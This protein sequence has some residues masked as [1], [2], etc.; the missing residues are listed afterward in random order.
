MIELSTG[1]VGID[2][3]C[4]GVRSLQATF[5]VALFL[6]AFYRMTPWRRVLLV[7]A[8]AC[9]AFVCNIGRTFLL[10]EVAANDGIAAISRWHDPAGFTIL[11]MAG[12]AETE[13][14]QAVAK[15]PVCLVMGSEGEGL[16]RLTRE[17]CDQ[18]VKI[19]IA[20]TMESLNMSVATGVALSILTRSRG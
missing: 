12:E 10:C 8:G 14:G 13:I 19:A 6:G 3:A 4:T 5:M 1:Q 16:R 20:P 2:D 15:G 18:L 17:H 7:V 9:L 11:G